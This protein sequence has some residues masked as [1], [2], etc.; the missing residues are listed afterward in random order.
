M[1]EVA[2]IWRVVK[3][4]R[5]FLNIDNV[6]FGYFPAKLVLSEVS[7]ALDKGDTLAVVGAS[8]R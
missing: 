5:M 2:S 8:G 1:V 3:T 7:F 4:K 6:S